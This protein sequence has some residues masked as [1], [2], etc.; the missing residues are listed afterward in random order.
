MRRPFTTALAALGLAAAVAVQGAAGVPGDQ[1]PP[2]VTPVLTGTLGNGDWY[3][4]NVTVNWR[5]SDP[6]SVILSSRGCD[7]TTLTADT[8]G[9]PLR[10]EATSDGGDASA[11]KTIKVD[12]TAPAVAGAAPDRGAD[13]AG[14]YTRPVTVAFSG[15]D[16]VSGVEG[17]STVTYSG[18]DSGGASVSG[19][20]RDHAGNVGAAGSFPLKFD[21]TAPA[22]TG[23]APD[24][25]PDNGGWYTRPLTVAF[26]GTDAVSGVEG[27]S[28]AT[29]SG[30]DSGT[31]SVSGTCR[32]RAGNVGPAGSYAF[33]Y[34]ANAPA[35]ADV[36]VRARSHE[37]TLS[38][39]SLAPWEVVTIRRSPGRRGADET[40]VYQGHGKSF[41]DR[42]LRNGVG[43]R[44]VV[45]ASD[46]ASNS[47]TETVEALPKGPLRAPAEEARVSRPP[48]LQWAKI[49][50]AAFYNVQLFRNGRKILS[51]WPV[52]PRL[53]LRKTWVWN[54]RRHK[55]A[56]AEYRWFVWPAYKRGGKV[57][58][59]KPLGHSD[60][61]VAR[62][63]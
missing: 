61:A 60:F 46:P 25:G 37:A 34:D 5:V 26:S 24:R 19:T 51:A 54:G 6:E 42:S 9:T 59:G 50:K 15:T 31:A 49:R 33:K 2:V 40:T 38:W 23:A 39:K 22:V 32:D 56:P 41:T 20:C 47:D 21:A 18:P 13:N 3:V 36:N 35:L 12:K 29:Y 14:W 8:A 1:T 58:Y 16:A 4:T 27:C 52:R 17:C 57:R 44:Y 30:P 43:Y 62:P 7:A 48:L 53:R 10:C 55:L 11:G 45:V 63:S 28:A